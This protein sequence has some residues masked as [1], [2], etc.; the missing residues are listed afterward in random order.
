MVSCTLECEG[1]A[2]PRRFF[3]IWR[4]VGSKQS[5]THDAF[6]F[7]TFTAS[8]SVSGY[9]SNHARASSGEVTF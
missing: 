3:V 1:L 7:N 8:T 6:N 9:I 4:N 5:S 2:L